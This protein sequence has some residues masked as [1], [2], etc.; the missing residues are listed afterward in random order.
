MIVVTTRL[1][2][3]AARSLMADSPRPIDPI[4]ARRAAAWS[5]PCWLRLAG[6]RG[7]IRAVWFATWLTSFM[8]FNS[9]W[10]VAEISLT[11]A[12]AWFVEAL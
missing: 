4:E 9:S 11:A 12:A 3:L 8:V 7:H 1:M 5:D 10:L 2:K 6:G